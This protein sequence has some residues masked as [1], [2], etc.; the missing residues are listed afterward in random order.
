MD[1]H[2]LNRFSSLI[3]KAS[4]KTKVRQDSVC[5]GML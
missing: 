5:A 1:L 2:D 4:F 3:D